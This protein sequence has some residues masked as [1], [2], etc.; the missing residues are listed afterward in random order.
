M[1]FA[2]YLGVA[3]L[4][5]LLFSGFYTF[6]AACVRRK[7]LPWLDE[8]IKSTHYGKYYSIIHSSDAF[9]R[10]NNAQDAWIE[11]VD[12]LKLHAHW[13][14]AEN[15]VGTVVLAH[16]YR[17]T[18]LVDFGA[19]YRIYHN[20]RMNILV[21]DQRSHG[22]SEGKVITFGVK[23]SRDMQGWIQWH[24]QHNPNLPVMLSGL[25]M[26]ASTMLYL[27]DKELPDNVKGIIA[28]CGFTSPWNIISSVFRNVT[29][30]PAGPSLWIADMF[31]RLFAGFHLREEDTRR[32]LQNS[33]IPV[34]MVHGTGDTFVPCDMTREAFAVCAEPKELLLVEGAEHGVSFLAE[35]DRYVETVKN[36][37]CTAM[38]VCL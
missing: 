25:S 35:P 18:K 37:I 36:F 33:R 38:G 23:E 1:H 26:G 19:V 16:G 2:L 13:I 28:D 27:A 11:S 24:N 6:W 10:E 29:H 21:P 31:A 8:S 14:P 34:L 9:L 15:P 4:L 5:L 30:L 20:L 32:S 12:G 17:S 3:I 22:Q 7:E